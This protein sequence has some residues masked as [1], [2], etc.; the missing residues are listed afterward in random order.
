MEYIRGFAMM[1]LWY[2]CIEYALPF[3]WAH[4]DF[5]KNAL[6]A[7]VLLTPLFALVGTM[8]VSNRMAFFSDVLGHSALT[9]IALGVWWGIS[10]PFWPMFIFIVALALLINAFKD[11]GGESTDTTLGVFFAVA[12]A[13]GVVLL[14]KGGGFA[15][16]SG[17]LIGDILAITTQQIVI[18]GVVF[19][20]VVWF[21]VRWG[22]DLMFIAVN[23]VL[24]RSR[25]INVSWVQAAFVVVLAVI[26][27]ISIKMVG[28]LIIN[29][30]LVLPAASA[31]ILAGSMRSY[32]LLSIAV[33][34]VSGIAGL[35]CSYYWGT[36]TGAT[37]VLFC[38]GW[39]ILF[40]VYAKAMRKGKIA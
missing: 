35:I 27:A 40:M 21:W 29:S 3:S 26:V 10:E 19:A 16:Y 38:A 33:S 23:P 18:L 2:R 11:I 17:F 6:L 1:D 4:Y 24:A 30:L 36:A 5:M 39:Y 31:R 14:S 13:L 28:I 20:A 7:L 32:T 9:G 12:V 22:N 37:I 8:V 25:G 15:K 34:L